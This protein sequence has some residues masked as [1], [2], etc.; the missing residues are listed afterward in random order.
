VTKADMAR[1][2][3]RGQVRHALAEIEDQVDQAY[4]GH[5]QFY[6]NRP[7]SVWLAKTRPVYIDFGRDHLARFETYDTSGLPCVRLIPKQT[8]IEDV[9]NKQD[10]RAIGA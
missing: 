7:R 1:R 6:W 9:I 10:V 2:Y 8:F 5:H 4:V 3:V